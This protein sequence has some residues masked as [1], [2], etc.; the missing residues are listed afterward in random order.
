MCVGESCGVSHWVSA[1]DNSTRAE[2]EKNEGTYNYISEERN[3]LMGELLQDVDLGFEVV[4][5]LGGK[6]RPRDGFHSHSLVRC[7]RALVSAVVRAEA[8]HMPHGI[9]YTQWQ[10][11]PCRSPG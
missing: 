1:F 2:Y 8:V 7:L 9:P 3:V 11:S 4:E 6:D 5:Q 10:R